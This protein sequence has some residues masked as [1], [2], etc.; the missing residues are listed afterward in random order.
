MVEGS[1]TVWF[2]CITETRD[3]RGGTITVALC[4][5]QSFHRLCSFRPWG[6]TLEIHLP[7]AYAYRSYSIPSSRDPQSHSRVRFRSLS[8]WFRFS[9]FGSRCQNAQKKNGFSGSSKEAVFP[10]MFYL[11]YMYVTHWKDHVTTTLASVYMRMRIY[12]PRG[13]IFG[14][15]TH[16]IQRVR[17]R[18]VANKHAGKTGHGTG[19]S[20]GPPSHRRK[21]NGEKTGLRTGPHA[22]RRRKTGHGTGLPTGPPPQSQNRRWK[23]ANHRRKTGHGTGLPTGP[24]PTVVKATLKKTGLQTGPQATRRRTT[25]HGTGLLTGPAPNRRNTRP[26]HRQTRQTRGRHSASV[27]VSSSSVGLRLSVFLF[28]SFCVPSRPSAFGLRLSVFGF[29][30]SAFGLRTSAF[31]FRL[32]AFGF[33]LSA[34]G[35]RLSAFGP[36]LGYWC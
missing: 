3:W 6:T 26:Q 21:T 10:Y 23:N 36:L 34:F 25:G 7:P 12:F 35:L 13:F 33:R 27:L 31:G 1:T 28:P 2:A 9:V 29:R 19:L 20:T 24:A 16:V 4:S 22:N 14:D 15:M 8:I 17:S 32:S 11:I 30:S 5:T 18:T